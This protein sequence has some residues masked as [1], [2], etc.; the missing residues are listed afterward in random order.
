MRHFGKIDLPGKSEMAYYSACFHQNIIPQKL[1]LF[2]ELKKT[3]G[4]RAQ[5]HINFLQVGQ[6]RRMYNFGSPVKWRKCT[7]DYIAPI[8]L[9]ICLT[10]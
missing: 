4:L 6:E 10:P 9:A 7:C 2:I 3:K 8:N 1:I 5:L